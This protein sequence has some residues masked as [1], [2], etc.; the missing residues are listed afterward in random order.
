MCVYCVVEILVLNVS[1][2]AYWYTNV[3]FAL[4]LMLYFFVESTGGPQEK[5]LLKNLLDDYNIMN[6]PVLNESH[7]LVLTFGVTLQQIIDVVSFLVLI[8]CIPDALSGIF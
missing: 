3:L 2:K 6:R 7:P 8:L 1:I 5:R 4:L